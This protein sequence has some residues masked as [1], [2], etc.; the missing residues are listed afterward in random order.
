MTTTKNEYTVVQVDVVSPPV[1]RGSLPPLQRVPHINSTSIEDKL[2]RDDSLTS[3]VDPV[4]AQGLPQVSVQ[5]ADSEDVE[6]TDL[7][8]E[9]GS[10]SPTISINNVSYIYLI[11]IPYCYCNTRPIPF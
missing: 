2:F 8:K 7:E 5:L 11:L 10:N 9:E 4:R 6:K 3:T 1:M